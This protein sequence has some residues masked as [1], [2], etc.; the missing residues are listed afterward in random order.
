MTN[1]ISE[2]KSNFDKLVSDSKE[3]YFRSEGSKLS[4]T[5]TDIKS[6]WKIIKNFVRTSKFPSIPPI[7]REGT[8]VNDIQEKCDIFNNFFADQ[9]TVLNTGSNLPDF[10]PLT[11][12][13]LRNVTLTK[14]LIAKILANLDI[15]KAS[16]H[17]EISAKM[18]KMC[19]ESLINPLYII[20]E[21]CL[22][23][24][25]FPTVWK[26]ANVVPIHKKNNK[27][28]VN[29]YRP[30]SLLPIFGKIF[31]KI[32]FDSLYSYLIENKMITPKQ[33]GFIKGDSTINQ[34]LSIS[35]K[36]H[37]AFDC[38]IP[39][40]V[41]AIFLDISKAFDKVWH[42]GLLFKLK[43]LGI[44]DA[45]LNILESFFS[46]KMSKNCNKW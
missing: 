10:I 37:E 34:L 17:D 36:I 14:T 3:N 35:Q 13:K 45:M 31:E 6:Y 5:N 42:P 28:I 38:E 43:Q 30:I 29:N 46:R 2:C 25:V 44:D 27:E 16:G 39:S 40:E 1:E 21:N 23:R 22:K 19:G 24:G 15:N 8:Y 33:S 41:Y 12:L 20:M 9:C 7:L 26:Q 32:I 18:I 4:N 11:N